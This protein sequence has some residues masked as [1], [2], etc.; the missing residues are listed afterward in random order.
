MVQQGQLLAVLS[1]S[2][3]SSTCSPAR[4]SVAQQIN[5]MRSQELALAQTSIGNERAVIEAELAADKARRQYEMQ[6]P[7]AEKGFVPG[8]VFSDSRDEYRLQPAPRRRAAPRPGDR[9]AAAV[10]PARPAARVHRLAERQPRHRPRDARRA[11]PARAGRRPAHRFL[12]P[13]RPVAEPRRAARPDR[14]RRPQ[15]AGRA[16][17]TNS[18]S[19]GS[20]PARSRPSRSGGKTYRAQG[21]QNL[22]AGPQRRVRGRPPLHRRTSRPSSSAARRCRP[23]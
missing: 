13:G 15:Q 16:A 21:R 22:S 11:Q 6:R 17:S 5:S 18:I 20:S 9:R 12:D 19:A 2:D 1:N 10:E 14:Q 23:S 8:K 7:L 3:L 4:P